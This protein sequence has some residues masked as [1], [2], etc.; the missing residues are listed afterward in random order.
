MTKQVD[1]DKAMKQTTS[2]RKILL[3]HGTPERGRD[4]KSYCCGS[5]NTGLV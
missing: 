5:G 4:E 3:G 2:I 1:Y